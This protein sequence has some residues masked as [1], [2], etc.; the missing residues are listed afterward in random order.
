MKDGTIRYRAVTARDLDTLPELDRLPPSE[1][2]AMRAVAAVLPFRTNRYVVDRLIDWD[3][4]PDDPMFQLTFPQ[5]GMLAPRDLATMTR[6]VAGGDEAAVRVAAREI[7]ARLNPH[8][9]G[10]LGLNVPRRG[11]EPVRGLQHKYR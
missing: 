2:L 7:Q 3:R 8:P 4:V 9:A 1:R 5:P 11:D 10:Q 6:L